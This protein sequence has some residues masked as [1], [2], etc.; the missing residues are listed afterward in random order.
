MTAKF[1]KTPCFVE[2]APPLL[3]EDTEDILKSIGY[4]I[5]D[6]HNLKENNII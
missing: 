2:S 6:I 3:S 4:S 5:K 1:E